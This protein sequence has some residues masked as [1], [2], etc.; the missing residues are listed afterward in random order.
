MT[1]SPTG[2]DVY[3]AAMAVISF[4]TTIQGQIA[5]LQGGTLTGGVGADGTG[6]GGYYPV[7]YANMVTVFE[8]CPALIA[9]NAAAAAAANPASIN[10]SALTAPQADAIL[11]QFVGAASQSTADA[12]M[13][14]LKGDG[15]FAEFGSI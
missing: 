11:A 4:A 13:A 1:T 2:A 10:W 3:S 9:A 6:V 12:L 8:P 14:K 7:T 5:A 15:E